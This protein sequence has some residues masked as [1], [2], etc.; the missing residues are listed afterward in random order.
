M[1][2]DPDPLPYDV[3]ISYSRDDIAFARKLHSALESY[4]PAAGLGLDTRKLVVFR[5]ET[6]IQGTRYYNSID[7]HLGQSNKLLVICS[8]DARTSEYV[9][10][11]ISRFAKR[12]N[13]DDIIPVLFRGKPNNETRRVSEKAFPRKLTSIL[14]T[15]LAIDMR[16]FDAR[17]NEYDSDTWEPRW[18]QLL[19][20]I[21]GIERRTIEDRDRRRNHIAR[22]DKAKRLWHRAT[23][24]RASGRDTE[25]VHRLARAHDMAPRG[26]L[27][28]NLSNALVNTFAHYC[29]VNDSRAGGN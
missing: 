14:K 4:E 23:D 6:D 1:S 11:E 24:D 3:F 29:P 16:G 10:D 18:Y 2:T 27:K 22:T 13:V 17:V 20:N 12:R 21:F 28:K 9:N 26:P 15:P 5:D 7:K 19:S 8:P 25:Y